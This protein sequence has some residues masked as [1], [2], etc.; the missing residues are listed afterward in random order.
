MSFARHN[1]SDKLFDKIIEHSDHFIEIYIGKYGRPKIS[2]S[3][4]KII[5]NNNSDSEIVKVITESI[6]FVKFEIP[7]LISK[8]DTDLLNIL[9]D[10]LGD[11]N[12]T[13]YLYTL[14]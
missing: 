7:K 5:L 2:K 3:E 6:H 8:E 12:Q 9:D 4:D 1:A 14:N 13:L 10:F 11:L